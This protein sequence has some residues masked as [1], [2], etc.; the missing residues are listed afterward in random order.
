[1]STSGTVPPVGAVEGVGAVPAEAGAGVVGPA[2]FVDPLG[3]V[4]AVWAVAL[5]APRMNNS[6]TAVAV[7]L[8]G[9]KRGA[10]M[11]GITPY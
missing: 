5:T 7:A 9:K 6:A 10:D 11:A 8:R 2:S 3:V 4:G 1:M